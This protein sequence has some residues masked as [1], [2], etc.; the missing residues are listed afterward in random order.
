MSPWSP[1][2]VWCCSSVPT[3]RSESSEN[4]SSS[5]LRRSG[6]GAMPSVGRGIAARAVRSSIATGSRRFLGLVDV[7][8]NWRDFRQRLEGA[9][10]TLL[11][12][13]DIARQ[14]VH[15]GLCCTRIAASQSATRAAAA[16]RRGRPQRYRGQAGRPLRKQTGQPPCRTVARTHH[17][18]LVLSQGS[19]TLYVASSTNRCPA[20]PVASARGSDSYIANCEDDV[21][22]LRDRDEMAEVMIGA[23]NCMDRQLGVEVAGSARRTAETVQTPVPRLDLSATRLNK[24]RRNL[25]LCPATDATSHRTTRAFRPTAAR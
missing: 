16:G 7:G 2:R 15:L 23:V 12:L 10:R 14:F 9:R 6:S 11:D 20:A 5:S 13:G 21:T 8:V 22:M 17:S 19:D 3:I 18:T 1:Q 25:G 4:C 24:Q